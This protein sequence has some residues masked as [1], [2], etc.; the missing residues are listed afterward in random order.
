MRTD[1][2]ARSPHPNPTERNK[3]ILWSRYTLDSTDWAVLS[4]KAIWEGVDEKSALATIALVDGNGKVIIESMIKSDEMISSE[5]IARHG[6]EQ[7]V[8]F[9]AKA[10]NDVR[11]ELMVKASGKEILVWDAE[12]TQELLDKLDRFYGEEPLDWH[13]HDVSSEFARY[14][15]IAPNMGDGPSMELPATGIS[16]RAECNDIRGVLTEMASTSQA[17]DA[18]AGGKPGWTAEF[19]RP[20]RSPKDKIKNIFGLRE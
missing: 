13:F 12:G 15:G 10:Y 1:R 3:S 8:V 18:V 4:L 17:T 5:S 6:V 2:T 7:S 14:L 16:A 9:H 20:K 11:A 19:Y